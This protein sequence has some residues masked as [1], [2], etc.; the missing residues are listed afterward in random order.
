MNLKKTI[1]KE[2]PAFVVYWCSFQ[3]VAA[4]VLWWNGLLHNP[5]DVL[6]WITLQGII[7]PGAWGLYILGHHFER[8]V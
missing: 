2:T 6:F 8:K 4:L 7:A 3:S 5:K 1:A